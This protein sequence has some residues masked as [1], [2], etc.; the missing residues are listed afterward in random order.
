MLCLPRE[1]DLPWVFASLC[2]CTHGMSLVRCAK[3]V[4]YRYRAFAWARDVE[5]CIWRRWP[6]QSRRGASAESMQT[7]WRSGAEQGYNE[8]SLRHVSDACFCM[9]RE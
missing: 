2:A 4:G 9:A 6:Q 3:A 7:H 8:V 5:A 1:L